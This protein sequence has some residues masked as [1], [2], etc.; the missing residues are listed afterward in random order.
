MIHNSHKI[1]LM[2]QV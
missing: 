1:T 2:S